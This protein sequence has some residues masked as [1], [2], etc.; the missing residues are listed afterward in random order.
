VAYDVSDL[1]TFETATTFIMHIFDYFNFDPMKDSEERSP[2]T[3]FL[4]ANK[5]DLYPEGAPRQVSEIHVRSLLQSAIGAHIRYY[6]VSSVKNIGSTQ[7]FQEMSR[8]IQEQRE[9]YYRT[10]IAPM[11]HSFWE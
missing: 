1:H 8:R 4:V 5:V 11:S 7:V 3:V 6:E 9:F 2:V 10:R